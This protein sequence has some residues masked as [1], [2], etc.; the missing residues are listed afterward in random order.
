M[1][2]L[3]LIVTH[4]RSI[5]LL[6]R[7]KVPKRLDKLTQTCSPNLKMQ[8]H[9]DY[10]WVPEGKLRWLHQV[11]LQIRLCE[12][13]RTKKRPIQTKMRGNI[14]LWSNRCSPRALQF[15]A[16]QPVSYAAYQNQ[17]RYLCSQFIHII[18]QRSWMTLRHLCRVALI[19]DLICSDINK[20]TQ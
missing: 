11:F 20:K 17:T 3:N 14:R 6:L 8:L 9:P 19:T 5:R 4:E 12:W 15:G 18:S 13:Y 2:G 1:N 7:T 16:P 10:W